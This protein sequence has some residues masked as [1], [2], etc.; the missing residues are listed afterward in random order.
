KW[1]GSSWAPL[2]STSPTN[3]VNGN[4]NAIIQTGPTTIVVGGAF[5]S[6]EGVAATNIVSWGSGGWAP[7]GPGLK[8]G[9]TPTGFALCFNGTTI[10]A[11]GNFTNAGSVA[12]SRVAKWDGVNWS[13]LGS[14][15][16]R[17]FGASAVGVAATSG[18]DLYLGGSFTVAG[19]KGSYNF[20]H[21]NSLKNFDTPAVVQLG[22]PQHVPG[23]S[24]QFTLAST[25]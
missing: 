13:P 8:G 22:N 20:A 18:N 1:S 15:V 9:S 16:T 5:T 17:T 4:V 11:G 19:G 24:V 25:N 7:L 21:W 10:Y 12:V 3:G 6:A 14:G 23:G 2:G